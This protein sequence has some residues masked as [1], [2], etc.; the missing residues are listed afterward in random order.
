MKKRSW[1]AFAAMALVA[2]GFALTLAPPPQQV[3][4][5]P[6]P[7]FHS[8]AA[9]FVCGWN[10][11]N[12]G[13]VAPGAAPNGEATV[14]LGNYATEINIFNPQQVDQ[15]IKKRVIVLYRSDAFFPPIGREPNVIPETGGEGIV[16]P[17]F[18]GTMDD[19]NKLYQLAGIP[20]V[21]P[22]T[23]VIG[24][25]VIQSPLEL[26]VTGVYTAEL[27]S[28]KGVGGGPANLCNNVAA[29]TNYSVSLS[30]DVEQIEGKV[31]Q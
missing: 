16:L 6:P 25:L 27:C 8:Y 17:I 19:C 29:G 7:P 10:K 2:A 11:S 15:D 20:I 22:P 13:F 4:A 9:K 26:D 12:T 1:L 21:N 28:D 31:I 23:L 30:I 24:W 3:A 14:K 18:F 5:Q